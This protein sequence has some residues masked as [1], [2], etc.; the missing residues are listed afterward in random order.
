MVTHPPTG[1]SQR[2]LTYNMLISSANPP[3]HA[4]VVPCYIITQTSKVPWGK[5]EILQ[6][7]DRMA[8]LVE[9]CTN[10]LLKHG[11]YILQ[12]M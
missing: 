6:G 2:C 9:Q 12:S 5:P 4:S 1:R 10:N 11:F 8:F 7:S 3:Y